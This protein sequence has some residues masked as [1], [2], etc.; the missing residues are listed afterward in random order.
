M[1][2]LQPDL[3]G[4]VRNT[5][6]ASSR[7]AA[8]RAPVA[9]QRDRILRVLLDEEDALGQAWVDADEL[10]SSDPHGSHR[11][12]WSARLAGMANRPVPL[13]V[14]DDSTNPV[15]FALTTAGREAAF[16]LRGGS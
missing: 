1:T 12:I 7:E 11:S 6:P 3:W 15:R 14:K 8:R 9:T 4:G 16:G 13:L 2:A 10:A 5:D